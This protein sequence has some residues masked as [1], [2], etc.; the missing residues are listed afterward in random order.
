MNISTEYIDQ[1]GNLSNRIESIN[2][3]GLVKHMAI[4]GQ[5]YLPSIKYYTKTFGIFCHYIEYLDS[6]SLNESRF[7]LPPSER[8][9]PTERGQFSNLVGKG[10]GD[11]L[12]R[13]LSG[14]KIT[15]GYEAAMTVAGIPISGSRPDLY[16]IGNGFQ[17]ALE[18]KGYSAT[19]I[20]AK[21]MLNHKSQ[22]QSGPLPV[23]FSIASV[24]YNLYELVRC[25]YHDP[26]NDSIIYNAPVNRRLNR[27]YYEG[28][29]EY[30]NFDYFRIEEGEI[31]NNHCYFIDILGPGTPYNFSIKGFS[32]ALILQSEFKRFTL[33]E[34]S[35]F[36]ETII[37]EPFLYLDTDGIGIC[38]MEFK[39]NKRHHKDRS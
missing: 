7:S 2:T 18:A 33:G 30:L 11:F 27:L 20:S 3:F 13:R 15:H 34:S 37:Q 29:F 38:L 24:S 36:N 21:E 19:T 31:Q 8:R 28:I 35:H 22:A 39:S 1:A 5:G 23:N 4:A 12:S 6:A 25:K 26:F 16:C 32:L 14:A 17:F 9:D 10:L